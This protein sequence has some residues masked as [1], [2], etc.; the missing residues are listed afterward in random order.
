MSSAVP[1]ARASSQY[2]NIRRRRPLWVKR[3]A[4][5]RLERREVHRRGRTLFPRETFL[6]GRESKAFSKVSGGRPE[7]ARDV[8]C[9]A[10]GFRGRHWLWSGPPLALSADH[11]SLSRPQPPCATLPI[12]GPTPNHSAY[13]PYHTRLASATHLLSEIVPERHNGGLYSK[14]SCRACGRNT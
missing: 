2:H 8:S 11:I 13:P 10:S 14:T 3:S 7:V 9:A 12:R 1:G 6:A 4:L 5:T